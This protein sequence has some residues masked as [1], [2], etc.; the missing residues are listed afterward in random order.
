MSSRFQYRGTPHH[1][2]RGTRFSERARRRGSS[3]RNS[4]SLETLFLERAIL[5]SLQRPH[6]G[7]NWSLLGETVHCFYWNVFEL[8]S[9]R[10]DAFDKMRKRRL[11]LIVG[12]DQLGAHSRRRL[13]IR[14]EKTSLYSQ[15]TAG[16]CKHLPKLSGAEYSDSH[17][18]AAGSGWSSTACVCVSRNAVS[19]ARTSGCLLPTIAAAR[20]AAFI[21]PAFPIA[22]VPTGT[23]AGIC[24]IDSSESIP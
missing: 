5:R 1:F 4:E 24:T 7:S 23:P 17:P 18:V 12:D 8:V 20:R 3:G 14:R 22:S 21:A 10:I 19:A 6:C 13:W 16:E 9:H 2:Q 11:V 15:P